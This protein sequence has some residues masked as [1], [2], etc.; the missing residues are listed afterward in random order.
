MRVE[1]LAT[2]VNALEEQES[3][4][5]SWGDTG[6]VCSEG[7]LREICNRLLP[8]FDSGDVL[9]AL[10]DDHAMVYCISNASGKIIGYRSRMA[11]AVHLYRNLRQWMHGQS[12]NNSRTLISDFRFLRRT[13]R[14]PKRDQE[15]GNLIRSWSS[16][17]LITPSIELAIRAQVGSFHLSGF[18][19][20]AT[21]R[22][23]GAWTRHNKRVVHS[24]ATIICSGTGSGKTL[25]FYLPALSCLAADLGSDSS[26]RVK[27]LAIYPRKELL[28]DQFNETWQACRRL[29]ELTESTAGRKIRIGALFSDVPESIRYAS[30][31]LVYTNS[32]LI[33]CST[34]SCG[35]EMRWTEEDIGKSREIL[36]CSQCGAKV[37]NDEI[38]LTRKSMQDSPPDILFTTTEMLNQQMGNP[39]RQ[40]LFGINTDKP[41]PVVLLD[42]VHTYGGNQG[43][44]TAFL[45][46]RWMKMA[47]TSPHF[48]GLSATLVDAENFFS[49]LTGTIPS[50]VR[51]IEPLEEEMI[52][53]GAEYLVALRGDPVSQ[54]ALLSTTIQASMLTRRIL[55]NHQVKPSS[56][57]WG[58]KSFVFTDDLD[59]NNRL[60]SQLADAEG[61][62][63]RGKNLIPNRNGPLAQ[64]RNPNREDS[65]SQHELSIFGQDWSALQHNGFSLD[66]ND[67]G[68]VSRTSSQDSGVKS[69]SDIVIATAS[70]E[71][72]YNDQAVGAVIQHKSP[73]TVASYL[74]R[75][76]RAGR[77]RIM[78]PWMIAILSDFGRDRVTYQH[79]EKL[80]D[81]E[82]ELQGLPIKNSHIQRMQAAMAT[83]NWMETKLDGVHLWAKLNK[84]QD[85]GNLDKKLEKLIGIIE[86]VLH[87]GIVQNELRDYL[88]DSLKLNDYEIVNI[89]WQPPRSILMEYLPTLR[90]RLK[91]LWGKWDQK[92]NELL[93][94]EETNS[95]W[96]S[97]MPEFI[98]D[99]LF[100]DLNLPTI[101]VVLDRGVLGERS[102]GMRFFQA[103]K[104][105]APG[106]ISKRF[107]THSGQSSDWV[108]P[109]NYFPS[110]GD[111]GTS[112]Y[113]ETD[114]VFGRNVSEIGEFHL[115]SGDLVKVIK[116]YRI[117]TKS[118]F[119]NREISETSNAF[120]VWHSDFDARTDPE[121]H[122]IPNAS[123]WGK[124][125]KSIDFFTHRSM[126]QV[127]VTRF[128]TGSAAEFKFK[129]SGGRAQVKFCWQK[130]GVPVG[131]GTQQS[132][133]AIRLE[134]LLR[135][136]D[137]F[138]WLN[139]EDLVASLRTGFFQEKV[140]NSTFVDGNQ[141]TADWLFEC[142]LAAF[143]I[144]VTINEVNIK[145]A[146]SNVS[147]GRA[148]FK[149]AN[150]PFVL[151]QQ[152]RANIEGGPVE[153]EPQLADQRLQTDLADLLERPEIVRGI[154]DLAKCLYDDL[155]SD[156][157]FVQWC[158]TLLGNTL[159]AALKQA[160]AVML[161]DADERSLLVDPEFNSENEKH[162]IWLSEE[163]S[164]GTGVITQLQ[165]LQTDDPLLF[166][167]LFAQC[168]QNSE[169]EQLDFDLIE[170]MK[171]CGSNSEIQDV[172]ENIRRAN[173]LE[174]R[175]SSNRMLKKVLTAQGIHYS[176][177]FASVLH[178]RVLKPGSSN[179]TDEDL[180]SYLADWERLELKVG[181]ELPL[182]IVAFVLAF[183]RH[184]SSTDNER[185]F[186]ESC[187][188]QSVL[189]PRGAQLRESA[190]QFY[191]P[192]RMNISN[193]TERKLAA[194]LCN[195]TTVVIETTGS[196][197]HATLH[198]ELRRSGRVDLR[199]PSN[200][201][202][203][204]NMFIS[205]IHTVPIDTYGMFVYPRIVSMRHKSK[206]ITLRV[207]LAESVF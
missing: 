85:N 200:K 176:H 44:Q 25:S 79:Y 105:F 36:T 20:R 12:L 188:I 50:R 77:T 69:N 41:V 165:D 103:L 42:E 170:L 82:I 145:Q 146:I 178:S 24:S 39:W 143:L 62:W 88:Q 97:P 2:V 10:V 48:V 180:A 173:D 181:L 122:Q 179:S 193:R 194:K 164:G 121:Q 148:S 187:A 202:S 81:P 149:L 197:W 84:P 64:L 56:G 61:W 101:E 83:L 86:D 129:R 7:E 37:G 158:F 166:L 55:D 34:I 23:L 157:T 159:S 93:A 4:L 182:N 96:G 11:H 147:S 102:E 99:Q 54:T 91:T 160:V 66:G 186:N 106:R 104:E 162:S 119:N 5:L 203:E 206:N 30:E 59:V 191:N 108:L 17:G 112:K 47:R 92:Y 70:L 156:V 154:T 155:S 15:I 125:L 46:R 74:Q 51:L 183:S 167:N 133:D 28:K 98:P 172:F 140:R 53:E 153:D 95:K 1:Q 204:L 114:W 201:H 171:S 63:Q 89:L 192:F 205:L 3:K 27:I 68:R 137:I 110:D 115:L 58:S 196:E 109:E 31:K 144:E 80:L 130:Q 141:F 174:S 90:R 78:R 113:I 40:K 190:L 52:E 71:V 189:W 45:L 76:G 134:Y 33:K 72:G 195:D 138:D 135:R 43:A 150:I 198:D 116:P 161:P 73:R 199:V 16:D 29:G 123:L 22:I 111:H 184:E 32:G 142:F 127:S 118:M 14:Y 13:R 35:G 168:L 151:F 38:M 57:L 128:N 21:E 67:R 185:I 75:K 19:K 131:I 107:S 152:N 8:D 49:R 26:A 6:G 132:V 126:T 94:W 207:E 163:D 177:S 169:Y 124:S 18:Q 9:D 65:P 139:D 136:S 175:I 117:T 60:Y 100:S 87:P 120:L